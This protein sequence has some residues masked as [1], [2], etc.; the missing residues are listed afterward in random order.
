M[1]VTAD[2][3]VEVYAVKR[4]PAKAIAGGQRCLTSTTRLP[5]SILKLVA[6]APAEAGKASWTWPGW[7]ILG[8]AVA[9][10]GDRYYYGIVAR[11]VNSRGASRFVISPTAAT[12]EACSDCTY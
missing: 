5:S 6:S 8:G 1:A 4:C 10:D 3:T 9:W 12:G 7:E 11:A 2:T